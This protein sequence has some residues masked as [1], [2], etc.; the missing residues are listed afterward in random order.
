MTLFQPLL[1]ML[2]SSRIMSYV[3]ATRTHRQLGRIKNASAAA[4]EHERISSCDASIVFDVGMHRTGTTSFANYFNALGYNSIHYDKPFPMNEL[5]AF[6]DGHHSKFF[7][8]DVWTRSNTAFSDWPYFA[9]PC[10]LLAAKPDHVNAKF[11]LVERDLDAWMNS[12]RTVWCHYSCSPPVEAWYYGDVAHEATKLCLTRRWELCQFSPEQNVIWQQLAPAFRSRAQR[13]DEETKRCFANRPDLL[14]RVRL[15]DSD[16]IKGQLVHHF[17][18]CKGQA[19]P[20]LRA[21]RHAV[22]ADLDGQQ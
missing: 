2:I 14:L 16:L 5:M 4:T 13:H 21:Q 3:D 18:G 17:L 19:R 12:L 1:S 10:Q 8:H 22:L 9:V 7:Q 15:E 6:A 20:I 11:I